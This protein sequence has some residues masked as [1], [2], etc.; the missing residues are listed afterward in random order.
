MKRSFSEVF[1]IIF[2]ASSLLTNPIFVSQSLASSRKSKKQLLLNIA[3][4]KKYQS[5]AS[6]WVGRSVGGTPMARVQ[7]W[8]MPTMHGN[9]IITEKFD[10]RG[11]A[12]EQTLNFGDRT[13][14][15]ID[16]D[17]DGLLDEWT[18]TSNDLRILMHSPRD[19]HFRFMEVRKET[20]KEW[21]DLLFVRNKF[22]QYTLLNRSAEKR[23]TL[24]SSGDS[25][26]DDF[27]AG[28]C[29]E[30]EEG[31]QNE[32]SQ[33]NSN[34]ASGV[35]PDSTVDSLIKEKIID[36]SCDKPEYA[37]QKGEI[38]AAMKKIFLSDKDF[39]KEDQKKIGQKNKEVF[40]KEFKNQF[41]PNA[42][43][44]TLL[45]CLRRY[46]MDTH[47]TRIAS[48]LQTKMHTNAW[49]WKV[50]CIPALPEHSQKCAQKMSM[51]R[52]NKNTEVHQHVN[53]V[54][55]P[56][57]SDA[58]KNCNGSREKDFF[59]EMLH[60]SGIQDETLV[61]NITTCCMAENPQGQSCRRVRFQIQE[62]LAQQKMWN[63][64]MDS[65]PKEDFE[66]LKYWCESM[67]GTD[68][69]KNVK[70]VLKNAS[71]SGSV[72]IQDPVKC[73]GGPSNNPECARAWKEEGVKQVKSIFNEKVC[74]TNGLRRVREL[75]PEFYQANQA[76]INEEIALDC[77][78]FNEEVARVFSGDP[79]KSSLDRICSKRRSMTSRL[80]LPFWMSF[81]V[82]KAFA[83]QTYGKDLCKDLKSVSSAL[84]WKKMRTISDRAASPL[85]QDR[86]TAREVIDAVAGQV[87]KDAGLVTGS[88]GQLIT[89][90]KPAQHI[91][92]KSEQGP[93]RKTTFADA[94]P[95][96]RIQKINYEIRKQNDLGDRIHKFTSIPYESLFP[97]AYA[98]ASDKER[99]LLARSLTLPDPLSA[100]AGVNPDRDSLRNLEQLSQCRISRIL[101][102]PIS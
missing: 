5:V 27:V 61:E 79:D 66:K 25:A 22:G 24:Y 32:V 67:Y 19:G 13:Q 97:S 57:G 45:G 21:V 73:A 50:Q 46:Q 77:E 68:C 49:N 35:I 54:M 7:H 56:P 12:R 44:P 34:L 37:E 91:V 72:L 83:S 40:A 94:T 69:D 100:N 59:H 52:N 98:K 11:R 101:C 20:Q 80:E 14:T 36:S 10:I 47:A 1:L 85:P 39:S 38:A 6:T 102:H 30:T 74:F 65:I 71:I 31:L 75:E 9:A 16:F 62:K 43:Q 82:E 96:A 90:Q 60:Y 28:Q 81:N 99:L 29:L 23:F 76:R 4:P 41:E 87:T 86:N 64:I 18:L 42:T 89:Q 95:S 33:F 88:V 3:P 2:L 17:G 8:V 84:D 55:H 58:Q 78:A 53:F 51:V 92:L 93:D 70:Q 15:E 26:P 63:M 48:A